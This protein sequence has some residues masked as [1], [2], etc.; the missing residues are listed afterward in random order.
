[1]TTNETSFFRDI[2]PF[3]ML[4]KVLLPELIKRNA[5]KRQLSFWCGAASTGQ[6]PCSVMMTISE[7]FPEL[8]RWNF[9]FVATDLCAKVLAQAR[10]GRFNQLEVN[11]GLPI[12]LLLKYFSKTGADWE[13]RPEL[14]KLIDYRE[15]NLIKDWP[16]MPQ[17]DI[18]FLR[19]VLIYF[20]IETKK[21]IL[22]NVRRHLAPG[23]Y[24]VL[25]SAESTFTIDD[26]F[27]RVPHGKTACY[28]VKG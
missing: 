1:M 18:V 16:V 11:R 3:D 22:A 15:L 2:H 27:E 25:G 9:R 4:Q 20:D 5:T 10:L 21:Q 13:F 23:G 28:R 14:R 24:L 17:F 26:T 19:N 6:E 12:T 7:N 8:L